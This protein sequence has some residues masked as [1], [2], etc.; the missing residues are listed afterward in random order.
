[1]G[2]N[3]LCISLLAFPANLAHT[4]L[5]C[6]FPCNL[7]RYYTIS[8]PPGT[9]GTSALLNFADKEKDAEDEGSDRVAIGKQVLLAVSRIFNALE[10]CDPVTPSHAPKK[11]KE[12]TA[13]E[14]IQKVR[15]PRVFRCSHFSAPLTLFPLFSLL[16]NAA[17]RELRSARSGCGEEGARGG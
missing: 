17:P 8:L 14:W 7:R 11:S 12:D 5:T 16:P 9:K 13:K 15:E 4:D 3:W 2:L 6:S 1:M 10:E